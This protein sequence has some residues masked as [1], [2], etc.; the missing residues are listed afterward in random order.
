MDPTKPEAWKVRDTISGLPYGIIGFA[1]S[2]FIVAQAITGEVPSH[3]LINWIEDL[4]PFLQ[5]GTTMLMTAVLVNSI[6]DLPSAATVSPILAQAGNQLITQ[7]AISALNIGC[8]LTPIGALAGIIF[9]HMAK[10]DTLQHLEQAPGPMT[11]MKLGTVHF[12]AATLATCAIIPGY[13][14]AVSLMQQGTLPDGITPREATTVICVGA[15]AFITICSALAA[16]LC[17]SLHN[18]GPT[19]PSENSTAPNP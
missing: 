4:P 6:N 10:E 12:T 3:Q 14:T 19:N 5:A 16:A 1:L 18:T 2:F 8:Y 17:T 15:A 13:N 11:L 7:S 9:F